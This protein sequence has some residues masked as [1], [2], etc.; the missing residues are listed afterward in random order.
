MARVD[1]QPPRARPARA[2][3]SRGLRFTREGRVFVLVTLGVGAAAV[4]TGNNLLYLVLGLMLSLILVSGVLSDLVLLQIEGMRVLPSRAFAGGPSLVEIVL[5]NHKARLPSFSLEVE[6]RAESLPTDRRCYFLKVEADGEQRATYR[7]D[8]PRR[9]RVSFS[10]LRVSTRYPFGLFDKWR[11][12][13]MPGELLVFPRVDGAARAPALA[14]GGEGAPDRIVRGPGIEPA[15]LRDY[16]IGDEARSLHGRRSAAL[17]RL[18]VRER[19]REAS[20]TLV[21]ALDEAIDLGD[22]LAIARLE[23]AI[24]HVAGIAVDAHARGATVEIVCRGSSSARVPPSG[25]LDPIFAHLALLVPI[26]RESAPPLE[27][28]R[29]DLVV[30]P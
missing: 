29:A 2:A 28:R 19:E 11:V 21:V 8:L 15:G 22:E 24:S 6:D 4:N 7:R 1:A 5:R 20:R 12:L 3:G 10:A 9:G 18:V 27:T 30:T 14:S 25:S 13:P 26:A 17:G 16:R 23:R